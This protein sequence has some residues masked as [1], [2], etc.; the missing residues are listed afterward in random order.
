MWLK[1]VVKEILNSIKNVKIDLSSSGDFYVEVSGEERKLKFRK[2]QSI[3]ENINDNN[4]SNE[5]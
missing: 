2:G 5:K 3:E 1:D 4:R